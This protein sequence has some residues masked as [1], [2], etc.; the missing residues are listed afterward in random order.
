MPLP[1]AGHLLRPIS[2]GPQQVLYRE[3]ALTGTSD[4]PALM[5]PAPRTPTRHRILTAGHPIAPDAAAD[6]G[7]GFSERIQHQPRPDRGRAA[8]NN[9]DDR[10]RAGTR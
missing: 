3:R 9:V 8:W 7:Y 5:S 4:T 2:P 6:T 10:G 1:L